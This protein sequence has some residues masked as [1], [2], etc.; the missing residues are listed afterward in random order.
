MNKYPKQI[1]VKT[2]TFSFKW[3]G[4]RTPKFILF[5]ENIK[6]EVSYMRDGIITFIDN[7]SCSYIR[8]YDNNQTQERTIIVEYSEI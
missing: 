1:E 7:T 3:T 5:P 2:K 6:K 8:T 4:N